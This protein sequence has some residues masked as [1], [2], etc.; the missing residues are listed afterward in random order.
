[1]YNKII[2]DGEMWREYALFT[3]DEPSLQPLLY[4]DD[5]NVVNPLGNKVGKCK[6]SAFYFPCNI[7]FKV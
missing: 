7:N 5:F 3:G 4:H 2:N 6:S 1:M